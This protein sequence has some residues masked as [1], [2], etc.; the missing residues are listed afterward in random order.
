MKLLLDE[1]WPAVIA[2]QLRQRGYDVV[3]V[4]ERKDL[5]TL[6]DAELFVVAQTEERAIVT[7]NVPDF[8]AIASAEILAGRGH[9]GL[10]LTTN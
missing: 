8:R 3:A 5:R 2:E 10:V 7:E 6:S 1:M 4:V 9:V